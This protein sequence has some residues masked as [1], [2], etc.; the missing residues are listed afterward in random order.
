MDRRT[1]ETRLVLQ[2]TLAR[3]ECKRRRS[4]KRRRRRHP[5]LPSSIVAGAD[6]LNASQTVRLLQ[7]ST[8][9][10]R[11]ACCDRDITARLA[12]ADAGLSKSDSAGC[13]LDFS[14]PRA[15][16]AMLGRYNDGASRYGSGDVPERPQNVEQNWREESA[17][18][19][20]GGSPDFS[21]RIRAA[22]TTSMV[23]HAAHYASPD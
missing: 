17:S 19:F 1:S 12:V 6:S 3:V 4:V 21:A 7:A 8:V 22:G 9:T 2:R 10:F 16:Q 14:F 18:N 13:A 20:S 15:G 5:V 23:Y 11:Q